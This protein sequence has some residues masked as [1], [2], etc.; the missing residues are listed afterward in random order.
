VVGAGLVRHAE[1]VD[2]PV[3]CARFFLLV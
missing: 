1:L 2:P 3:A